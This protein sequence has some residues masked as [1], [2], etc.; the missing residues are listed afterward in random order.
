M[1]AIY[2][3]NSEAPVAVLAP[4]T[5]SDCFEVAF[6]ASR[7]ALEH[8]TPVM[9]LSDGYIAN[10]A[11]PWKFPSAK[12]MPSIHPP[13]AKEKKDQDD[14]EPYYPYDR[15]ENYIRKWAVPGMK[16]L[17]HRIGG[18]EKEERTGNVSYDPENHERMVAFREAKV[19]QVGL[20]VPP[21]AVDNGPDTGEVLILG[22]GSTYGAIKT[23]VRDLR[24]E[25]YGVAHVHLRYLY[26]LPEGLE[27]LLKGFDRVIVPEMNRGQLVRIIRDR[28]LVDAKGL[29]KVQGVPFTAQEIADEVKTHT[30]KGKKEKV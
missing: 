22:W 21:A 30:K 2:G 20:S 24:E 6:E 5:P 4:A 7:I 12:D 11:E 1:Q 27:S 17:Q 19:R 10:G 14:G 18:L 16:G 29:N 3:R 23:A 13:F 26:P 25:G 15:D 8:M 28:F 9:I